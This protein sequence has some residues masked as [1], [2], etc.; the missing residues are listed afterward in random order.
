MQ[1]VV[2]SRTLVATD[3]PD[4]RVTADAKSTALALKKEQGKNIWLFGG[5]TLFRC[6]L[7]EGLVNMIELA[8]MSILLGQDIS[9]LP[10]GER[11]PSLRLVSSKTLPSGMVGLIYNVDKRWSVS[12]QTLRLVDARHF[13]C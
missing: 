6:L 1:T 13:I 3:Y 8:V 2:C 9:L 10:R 4:V 11:S 7:D 12:V 5:G